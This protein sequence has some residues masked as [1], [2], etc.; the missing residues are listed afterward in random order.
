MVT[1]CPGIVVVAAAGNRGPEPMTIDVPGNNP[2]VI[3]VGTGTDAYHPIPLAVLYPAHTFSSAEPT[4][5][6][7]VK[8]DGR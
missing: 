7:F 5:E 6:G 3:T 1:C 4:H 2:Y 8:P